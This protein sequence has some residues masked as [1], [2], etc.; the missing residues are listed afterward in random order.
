MRSIAFVVASLLLSLLLVIQANA[1]LSE[2]K[3]SYVLT[4]AKLALSTVDGSSRLSK[5]FATS[6]DYSKNTSPFSLASPTQLENDDV[7]R[8]TFSLGVQEATGKKVAASKEGHAL[9]KEHVPHQTFVVLASDADEAA[10]HAWPI[11]VKP[12]T[13]KAS[14]NLRMDRIPASLLRA[15]SP[16]TLSLLIAN[17]PTNSAPEGAYS[18]LSLPLLSLTPPSSLVD[19]A[20][21]SAASSL[22]P[23]EKAEIDQGFHGLPEHKHTFG[24]PPTETMPSTKISGLASLVTAAV[25]WLFLVA[26]LGIIKPDVQSPSS[27]ALVLFAALAGLEGLAVRYWIGL[28]LFQMLPLLLGA[29]L[30]TIVVGRSALV[31]LRKRR[32]AVSS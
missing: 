7:I 20:V 32:L 8:L 17:F 27:K 23:R 19:A 5:E 10:S 11:V 22:S 14:W 9:G 16:L 31:E 18:P 29:G 24:I 3:L 1:A 28:T 25:P 13:G 15:P 12:S 2:P 30:V 4:S 6:A 21:Q 26:A